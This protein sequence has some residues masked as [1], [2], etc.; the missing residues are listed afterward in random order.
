M[1]FIGSVNSLKLCVNSVEKK[2][3]AKPFVLVY[4]SEEE[5]HRF[6]VIKKC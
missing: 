1:G 6:H 2:L 4:F 5:I 3:C